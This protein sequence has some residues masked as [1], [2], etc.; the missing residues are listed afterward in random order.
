VLRVEV[1]RDDHQSWASWEPSTRKL[2]ARTRPASMARCSAR[3]T[4]QLAQEKLS[5]GEVGEK[6][7]DRSC[8]LEEKRQGESLPCTQRAMVR[9]GNARPA[10]TQRQRRGVG[11]TIARA[12]PVLAEEGGERHAAKGER[13]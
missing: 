8:E 3:R 11:R 9:T 7:D 4:D 2:E 1:G 6:E 10:E 5:T 13:M 12:R